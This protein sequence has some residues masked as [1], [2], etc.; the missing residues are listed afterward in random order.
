MV[1]GPVPPGQTLV[2]GVEGRIVVA[3]LGTTPTLVPFDVQPVPPRI[4]A[5][6]PILGIPLDSDGDGRREGLE[7][8]LTPILDG[9]TAIDADLAFATASD[10]EEVLFFSPRKGELIEVEVSVDA[11]FAAR[12][13]FFLPPP[14]TSAPRTG[15]STLACVRP[16]PG[17]LDSRGEDIADSVPAALFCDPE[18]PSFD[19]SFTSGV[20]LAGDH[21]FVS[22]S[23]VGADPG[24]PNTQYRPGSVLVYDFDRSGDPT[25]VGPDPDTPVILTTGFNPTHVTAVEL[26]GR[27]FVLVTVSGAI[28]IEEDDPDTKVI[29]GAAIP[30]TD[31]AIDVIDAESLELVATV[32]LGLAALSFDELAIDPSG[33]MA[34]MGSAAGRVLY[35][36]DLAPL[37]A[38]PSS[39][40]EPL[41]LD[42]D[43]AVLFDADEPFVLPARRNGAP[44]ESC[45]GQTVGVAFNH[46]GDG[47]FATD[48]CDGT[49][50][51]VG[52]DVSGDPSTAELRERFLVFET[53][54]VVAPIRPDTLGLPRG[55][56]S[57]VVRPGVPGVDYTGPDVF[58]LVGQEEGSLC[59]LRVESR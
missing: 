19:S 29:E 15:L 55:P 37:P 44:P 24:R 31:A 26:A 58:V 45:P 46:A 13:N 22:T 34:L 3:V 32:P 57:V 36:I 2:P 54:N 42:R 33:R 40:A 17:T 7:V 4:P 20:A 51:V 1:Y 35:G 53:L 21:L 56:G 27:E 49:L 50:T 16:P 12:D 59:G 43:E 47:I 11:G 6:V 10:Y 38:L 30:L 18:I 39:V 14:G 23:N 41:V 9:V 52:T 5:T 28:G 48:F 8:P 25:V